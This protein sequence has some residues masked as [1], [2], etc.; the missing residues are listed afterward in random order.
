LSSERPNSEVFVFTAMTKAEYLRKAETRKYKIFRHQ[1]SLGE[2]ID[3]E[4][5][6]TIVDP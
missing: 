3:R 5:G 1:P 4:I 6:L 2:C